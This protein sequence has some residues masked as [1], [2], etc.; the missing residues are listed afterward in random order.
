MRK[1]HH[2][3]KTKENKPKRTFNNQRVRFSKYKNK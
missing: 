2:N 3:C 1:K